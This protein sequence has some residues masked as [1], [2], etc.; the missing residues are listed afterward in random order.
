VLTLAGCGN[1]PLVDTL[2]R[3]SPGD[4]RLSPAT[5]LVPEYTPFTF[6]VQGGF[7]P[8]DLASLSAT[9]T[10]QDDHTYVFGGGTAP[11]GSTQD[12][13]ID[14]TDLLGNTATAV[15]TVYALPPLVLDAHDVTLLAGDFW[16]F[17]ATGGKQP[18]TWSLE[19]VVQEPAPDTDDNY[20]FQAISEGFYTLSVSDDIGATRAAIV[21]VLPVPP[22]GSALQI[23]PVSATVLTG[24]KVVFTAM[25]GTGPYAFSTTGG[26]ITPAP[27]P[28]LDGSPATYTA[29]AV[30]LTYTITVTDSNSG[31]AYA[32]VDVVTSLN[33]ALKLAPE[34]PTVLA[35]EETIEFTVI[36]GTPP[37]IFST[38]HPDRGSI[39]ATGPRTALYTQLAANNVTV[40]VLDADGTSTST[41][42]NWQ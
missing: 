22:A 4:L 18:Y 36:G 16:T 32:T 42:V 7:L 2:Q 35:L 28:D 20:L 41:L 33:Q 11:A 13:L 29:P 27:A 34:S 6:I 24:G 31:A 5:A 14:A 1:L 8:Y 30:K 15:V 17:T 23:T 3:E 39:A 26:S 25:G 38:D 10:A 40:R 37:F 12:Y 21:Q 19:G 9:L